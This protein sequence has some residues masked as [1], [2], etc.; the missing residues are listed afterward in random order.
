MKTRKSAY[1]SACLHCEITYEQRNCYEFVLVL[2]Q[3]VDEKYSRIMAQTSAFVNGGQSDQDD[4][5]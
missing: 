2:E 5:W 1:K 4:D 3:W